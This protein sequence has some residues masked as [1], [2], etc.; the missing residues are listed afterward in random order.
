M[1]EFRYVMLCCPPR[2]CVLVCV[3]CCVVRYADHHHLVQPVVWIIQYGF[4]LFHAFFI[5]VDVLIF[6]LCCL[7][8]P[9]MCLNVNVNVNVYITSFL[10]PFASPFS[11]VSP[12]ASQ[13]YLGLLVVI[14]RG[15]CRY[16]VLASN[17]ITWLQHDTEVEEVHAPC[18]TL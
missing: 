16:L 5:V 9:C 1:D 6:W 12:A 2:F 11:F 17:Q 18:P 8:A 10:L 4:A 15:S 14:S 7:Y 13:L 3:S